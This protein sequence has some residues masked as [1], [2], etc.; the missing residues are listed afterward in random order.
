MEILVAE[1]QKVSKGTVL[2]LLNTEMLDRS[3]EEVEINLELAKTTYERQKSLWEQKIG[4]EMQLLQLKTNMEAQQHRLESLLA[5]KEMAQVKS[6]V[7]GV[8][9]VI[10]QKKGEIAGAQ[11]PFAKVVNIDRIKIYADVAESH[12]TKIRQGDEVSV[13]FPSLDLQKQTNILMTGNYI[14]PN[15]RT[16]RIRLDLQNT[17]NQIKPNLVAIV[18]IRDYL[19][20]EAISI[21]AILIK[22]DFRGKYTFTAETSDSFYVARKTYLTTGISNNNITEITSGLEPGMQIISEGY[23]RVIDGTPIRFH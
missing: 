18:K 19:A 2:A 16:F 13:H 22:E 4:S 5:Q 11:I 20:E 14:D 17:D 8:V 12:L 23:S 9:D 7:N 6:P 21:P 10:Y 3:I 15:N 1:G